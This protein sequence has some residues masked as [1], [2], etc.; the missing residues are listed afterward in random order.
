MSSADEI[1]A[2]FGKVDELLVAATAAAP[3]VALLAARAAERGISEAR[4]AA[5]LHLNATTM[6]WLLKLE[7]AA[8][9]DR[10]IDLE[11]ADADLAELVLRWARS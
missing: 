3:A 6:R 4:L 7:P 8:A 5:H 2:A 1:A 9:A 11:A 10:S